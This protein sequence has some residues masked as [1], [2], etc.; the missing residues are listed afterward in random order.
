MPQVLSPPNDSPLVRALLADSATPEGSVDLGI[1]PRDEMLAFLARSYDGDLDRARY[2]YFQSGA[3]IADGMA[4]VLRWRFGTRAA[5]PP[6]WAAPATPATPATPAIAGNVL[7]FASGYG[8]V[9]R[10]LLRFLPAERLWVSDVYADGVRFQEERFGVHGV[11]SSVLPEDFPAGETRFDAILVTSLFSH[12]AAERFVAWLRVLMRLLA[13]GGVLAFSV[14]DRG[15]L[16][17]GTEV[18]APGLLF[19]AISESGS[20]AGDD[21]GSA[22]VSEDFVRGALRQATGEAGG[23]LHRLPRGL[24]GF[25]DLYV[26]VPES[27]ADFSHLTYRNEPQFFVER[28]AVIGDGDRLALQGWAVQRGGDLA[29]VEVLL[30]DELMARLPI[31][32]ERPEVAELLGDR[33]LARAGWSGVCPLPAGASR[34]RLLR[35]RAVDRHGTT[36][37]LV[38][39]SLAG[40]LHDSTRNEVSVLHRELR[41]ATEQAARLTTEA[42]ALQA[43]IAAMEASRFWK[44]RNAWF[45]C[46]ALFGRGEAAAPPGRGMLKG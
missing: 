21:Y 9:T 15:L 16:P 5:T 38:A 13:P 29:A 42:A 39:N 4:Q 8:R 40:A 19:Q 24:C 32:A 46:K 10:F 18:P 44:L 7:D 6:T 11:V 22:W 41:H 27:G 28:C 17:P 33:R 37:P 36:F 1:D 25:Q 45:R 43:R 12:L 35:L 31:D 26:A 30:D 14:H 20:L 34:S 2:A 23:S 3:S